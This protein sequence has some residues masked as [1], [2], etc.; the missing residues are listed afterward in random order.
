MIPV[1]LYDA[2]LLLG[3]YLV[4]NE[5]LPPQDSHRALLGE[6][7]QRIRSAQRGVFDILPN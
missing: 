6:I 2:S 5:N 4:P 1:G 7:K 3:G